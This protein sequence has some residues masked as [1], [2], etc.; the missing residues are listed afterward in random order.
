MVTAYVLGGFGVGLFVRV[1]GEV[2]PKGLRFLPLKGFEPLS[3]K[4]YWRK[5]SKA[6]DLVRE[7]IRKSTKKLSLGL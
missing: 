3:I 1:D 7:E 5:S 4:M 6:C 2:A